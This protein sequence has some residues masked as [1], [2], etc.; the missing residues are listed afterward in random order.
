M[1]K[2]DQKKS[3]KAGLLCA[4]PQNVLQLFERYLQRKPQWSSCSGLFCDDWVAVSH[5]RRPYL[6]VE[7]HKPPLRQPRDPTAAGE[8]F[9][10]SL[11]KS[12]WINF[13]TFCFVLDSFFF[14]F[15][16]QGTNVQLE[17]EQA[18]TEDCTIE[19]STGTFTCL[20]AVFKMRRNPG[21]KLSLDNNLT[22]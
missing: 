9:K 19:Y 16:N 22:F 1:T 6:Q 11:G 7:F 8:I 3:T 14:P 4:E 12:K 18:K 5:N 21:T 15:H 13:Q 17:L 2:Q 10:V 20:A